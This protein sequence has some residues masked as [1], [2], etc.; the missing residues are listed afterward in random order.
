MSQ[1]AA[2]QDRRRESGIASAPHPG[3]LDCVPSGHIS[4]GMSN[5]L[6][7]RDFHAWANQ[8]AALLRAGQLSDADIENIAEEIESMGRSEKREPIG[9]PTV[10]LLHPLKWRYQPNFRGN[11][12]RLT[13]EEQ[14]SSVETHLKE[15]PSLKSQFDAAI[16]E[17]YKAACFGSARETGL[18]RKGFPADC[19]FTY[20]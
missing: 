20:R 5:T 15:N 16:A 11:S 8:Q 19:P 7:E 9:R 10:L 2:A 14:R 17:G 13:I 6:Y 18:S 1:K 3:A 12:W 4:R